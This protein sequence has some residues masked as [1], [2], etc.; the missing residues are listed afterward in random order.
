MPVSIRQEPAWRTGFGAPAVEGRGM[1]RR[2]RGISVPRP[3]A[4]LGELARDER[5]VPA[6]AHGTGRLEVVRD[7]ASRRAPGARTSLGGGPAYRTGLGNR[8][9]WFF[10]FPTPESIKAYGLRKPL[11]QLARPERF[12]LPTFWFVARHSIQL[13]YG[14][15][16]S[17]I[18]WRRERDSNPRRA[19][20][21]YTL[22][23]G[24]PSTTRPSLRHAESRE[25]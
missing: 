15:V 22:S 20:D 10:D 14:R 23:R 3:A 4:H 6:G 7:G 24:A 16:F 13:S 2:D 18:H 1:P 12:E 19:F 17:E 8:G 5:R 25:G 11:T 21:P 9:R